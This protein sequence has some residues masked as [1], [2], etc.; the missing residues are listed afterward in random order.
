MFNLDE[1][2]S[3]YEKKTQ[4]DWY[5]YIEKFSFSLENVLLPNFV[6]TFW[7]A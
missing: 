1:T 3:T 4:L 5:L 2:N 7:E 6:L